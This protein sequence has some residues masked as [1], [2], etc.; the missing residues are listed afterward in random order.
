MA[1]EKKDNL[2]DLGASDVSSD[3]SKVVDGD[4]SKVELVESEDSWS[5]LEEIGVSK[6]MVFNI[7]LFLVFLIGGAIFVVFNLDNWF[8]G[9]RVSEG[10]KEVSI[11]KEKESSELENEGTSDG[12]VV[13]TNYLGFED[14]GGVLSGLIVGIE[15]RPLEIRPISSFG[16]ATGAL[17]SVSLGT[18][19]IF[20]EGALVLYLDLLK[21]L[22]NAYETD[23]YNV[24]DQAVDRT[25]ALD[26]HVALLAALITEGNDA[27]LKADADLAALRLRFETLGAARD[28]YEAQFFAAVDTYAGQAAEENFE[29]FMAFST[30]AQII[31]ARFNALGSLADELEYAVSFLTPRYQDILANQEAILKGVRVFDL[32]NSEIDAIIDVDAN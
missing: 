10:E 32:P 23:V 1:D 29:A 7:I 21:R 4:L 28:L 17:S 16:N 6:K 9:E 14:V 18:A 24:V 11:E 3:V 2:V 26:E 27:V 12:Q 19:D 15:F 31:R 13:E 8:G 30:E 20:G 5:S 22:N 25:A